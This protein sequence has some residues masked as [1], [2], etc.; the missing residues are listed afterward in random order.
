MSQAPDLGRPLPHVWTRRPAQA[1]AAAAGA[2]LLLPVPWM[3]AVIATGRLW[4]WLLRR[5]ARTRIGL[6]VAGRCEAMAKALARPL[7]RDERDYS[8]LYLLFGLGALVPLSFVGSL[9]LQLALRPGFSLAALFAYHVLLMGPYFAFFA[10]VST[11]VHKEGHAVPRGLFRPP[12]A[13]LNGF[14]G[15]FLGL[16]YGHVPQS[17]PLGHLRIHHKHDN[18]FDDL[19]T[20]LHL[21]R[22]RPSR[23]LMYLPQ[24]ALYWTGVSVVAYFVRKR[25]WRPAGKML[26][27]TLAFYGLGALLLV[28]DWR[29]ALGY[30]FLPQWMTVLFLGAIGYT[31]HAFADPDD[32]GNDYVSSVTLLEGHYNVFNEDYHVVHHQAPQLHWAEYPAHYQRHLDEYRRHFATVFRD[33]QA[34]ELFF[35]IV[36]RRYDLM[37]DHFVDLSG[38]LTREQITELLLRR[39]RP[40]PPDA[41]RVGR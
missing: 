2:L 15:S 5:L 38:T 26:L 12:F 9:V 19:I 40:V 3:A 33:T 37:T 7:L 21:D 18:G 6:G 36:L 24:F 17:Y 4:D 27:G 16:F 1:L 28:L 13:W 20:T 10:H 30:W 11:L 41:G 23:F 8:Y 31:W 22:R 34:F 32:P 29:V 25:L 35:W 14:F 39:L